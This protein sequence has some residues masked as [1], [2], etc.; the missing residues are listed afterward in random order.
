M[1]RSERCTWEWEAGTE[2]TSNPSWPLHVY[3]E[4]AYQIAEQ[5]RV[6]GKPLGLKDCIIVGGMGTGGPGRLWVGNPRSLRPPYPDLPLPLHLQTWWPRP[7][8]CPGNHMWSSPHQGV[9]LTTS[10]APTLL[11]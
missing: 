1:R 6:L 9:W 2:T 3:R 10:V 11:V 8:S 7:W 5:F 4:L